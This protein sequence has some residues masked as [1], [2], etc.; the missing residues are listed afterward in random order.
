MKKS[1]SIFVRIVVSLGL[2]WYV[3][4]KTEVSAIVDSMRRIE[5]FWVFW[6]LVTLVIGK[7]LTG[8]RWQ[9][10]LAAHQIK[11]P[12][13]TLIA[14]LYVGQFFNNFLPSTIGGD[15]IR[16]YDTATYSHETMKSIAVVFVDRLIGVSAL[17]FLGVL[18]VIA[19][20]YTQ[21]AV[22]SF[23]WLIAGAFLSCVIV[24]M[25]IFNQRIANKFDTVLRRVGIARVANKVNKAYHAVLVLREQ[26]SV[27]FLAF[28]VS[29]VLQVNVVLFY[30]LVS[31]SLNLNI[32]ML[33]FFLIIPIVLIILL[34]P[35][36]INGIGISE[37]AYVFFLGM[38][39]TTTADAIA[40]SWLAFGLMLTQGLVG[41]VIFALRG[42]EI[43]KLR[44]KVLLAQTDKLVA[45]DPLNS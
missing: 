45:E 14:S 2:L 41:G 18:A 13:P 17:A 9:K 11:I 43:R 37:S 16:A 34:V 30:Y 10:L 15:A 28:I 33:Y 20:L 24:L 5:P 36:S 35:F 22:A 29:V 4:S 39:G 32:S 31:L 6:A 1:I 26:K 8:Y 42:V 25:V 44:T 38:V 40:L 21:E 12:L 23:V 19:G 27:L 3:L 7:V